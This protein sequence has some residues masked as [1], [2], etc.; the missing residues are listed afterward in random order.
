M[1]DWQV[2]VDGRTLVVAED[3]D[4]EGTPVIVHHGT[5]GAPLFWKE[6]LTGGV[7]LVCYARPGYAG[8]T[9]RSGRTVVDAARDCAAVADALGI[10]RFATWGVSGGGPHALA[11]A[12]LLPDRVFAVATVGGLAPWDAEDFDVLDGMLADNA[13]EVTAARSGPEALRG[14]LAPMGAAMAAGDRQ[15][16]LNQL[17]DFL[18]PL[19]LRVARAG[20]GEI[21]VD[22]IRLGLRE[23]IEGWLDD[24]LAFARPWGFD[25]AAITCP[26]G[27]WHGGF[28]S[29]VPVA[30]G[31]WLAARLDAAHVVMPADDG[32]LA[33]VAHRAD[34]VHE[35]LLRSRPSSAER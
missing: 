33:M 14:L 7:R 31:R 9:P 19:D 20:F 25:L 8:S 5:P 30:H 28:D 13:A 12:A 21:L 27:V 3:G 10:D 34:E 26:V 22:G 23:G 24:D 6:W 17:A 11:T 4:P 2:D 29:M 15:A 16:M 18:D 35:W 1:R 32:H